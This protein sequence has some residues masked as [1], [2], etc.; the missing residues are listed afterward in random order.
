MTVRTVMYCFP[1]AGASALNTAAWQTRTDESIVLAGLQYP[2][3]GHR[4]C[5]PLA[6]SIEAIAHGLIQALPSFEPETTVFFGHSMG[7]LVAYEVCR[8]LHVHQR[9]LPRALILSG[10]GSPHE[11]RTGI[12]LDQLP[13]AE[14]IDYLQT[15][16]GTPPE[17]LADPDMCELLIPVARA[18]LAACRRYRPTRG[19]PLSTVMF[20]YAGEDDDLNPQDLMDWASC[21]SSSCTFRRFPGGHFYFDASPAAFWRSLTV[22]VVNSLPAHASCSFSA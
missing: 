1:H 22:D 8:Q 19:E 14:L 13:D 9:A 12:A 17:V 10:R 3:H 11:P 21:T 20:V 2:G 18:D 7:S 15:L 4:F 6:E 5:E 16:G